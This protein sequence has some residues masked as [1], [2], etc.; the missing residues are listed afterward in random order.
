MISKEKLLKFLRENPVASIGA[1]YKGKPIN[2]VVLTAI[3]NDFT[4]YFVT[5]PETYKAKALLENPIIS[6]TIWNKDQYQAQAMGIAKP[7]DS[8]IDPC[9]IFDKIINSLDNIEEFWPPV[10]S[11]SNEEYIIFQIKLDWIRVFDITQMKI[12]G[13]SS[14]FTTYNLKNNDK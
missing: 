3:D 7:I 12:K 1:V 14:L 13:N 11:M 8:S 10:I 2:S 6:M 4:F 5:N 9:D